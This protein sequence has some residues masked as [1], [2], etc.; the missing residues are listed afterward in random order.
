M[1]LIFSHN[2]DLT[3]KRKLGIND[4]EV[5]TIYSEADGT[6]IDE[7]T[8]PEVE[9]ESTLICAVGNETWLPREMLANA[10]AT[11]TVSTMS[12]T[13]DSNPASGSVTAQQLPTKIDFMKRVDK[14]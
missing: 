13:I 7:D 6:E 14:G 3:A 11:T 10:T 4:N 2:F 9:P 1:Y 12:L 8:F 5:I